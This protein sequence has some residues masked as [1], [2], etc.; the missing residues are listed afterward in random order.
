MS[1][2]EREYD[3]IDEAVY[4]GLQEGQLTTT[5]TLRAAVFMLGGDAADRRLV[6]RHFYT[7]TRGTRD[8]AGDTIGPGHPQFR[9]E[10]LGFSGAHSFGSGDDAL[11]AES[12]AKA[13]AC[14]V[15]DSP[16]SERYVHGPGGS[17]GWIQQALSARYRVVIHEILYSDDSPKKASSTAGE[18]E[19]TASLVRRAYEKL[20]AEHGNAINWATTTLT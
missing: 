11:I 17:P 2:Y 6:S 20:R 7:G 3:E 1:G 19:A 18:S 13:D 16:G 14:L 4:K 5:S 12:M 10:A 9:A 8:S 15:I